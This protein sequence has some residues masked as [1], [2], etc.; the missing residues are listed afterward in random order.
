MARV[1]APSW[2][3]HDVP[4]GGCHGHGHHR[5]SRPPPSGRRRTAGTCPRARRSP[6]RECPDLHRSGSWPAA[7]RG[8]VL[9]LSGG[10]LRRSDAGAVRWRFMTPAG[11]WPNLPPQH[12]PVRIRTAAGRRGFVPA[13]SL[14]VLR[15]TH[16]AQLPP[17]GAGCRHLVRIGNLRLTARGPDAPGM[18][19]SPGAGTAPARSMSAAIRAAGRRRTQPPGPGGSQAAE[20]GPMRT[21]RLRA[22]LPSPAA[23]RLRHGPRPTADMAPW[24]PDPRA[25]C[26]AAAAFS[27]LQEHPAAGAYCCRARMAAGSRP[28]GLQPAER[29]NGRI[30]AAVGGPASGPAA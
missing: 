18:S 15:C 23:I 25:G 9:P 20:R 6:R 21:C 28:A 19:G 5:R 24:R 2:H 11:A 8:N 26:S 3:L 27:G 29:G 4:W 22:R 16:A 14:H 10:G 17:E 12:R 30:R 7:V 13:R 1:G